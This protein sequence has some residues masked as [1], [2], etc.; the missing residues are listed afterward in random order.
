MIEAYIHDP[1][2]NVPKFFE[3]E[4]PSTM[5]T[6]VEDIALN[7]LLGLWSLPWMIVQG[8]PP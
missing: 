3:S 4:E 5:G 8:N 7:L 1:T 6:V 2:V